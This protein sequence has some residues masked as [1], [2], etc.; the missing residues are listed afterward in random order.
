[1]NFENNGLKSTITVGNTKLSVL[2][3]AL[4]VAGVIVT[5]AVK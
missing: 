5:F 1:M 3:L 4:V 2:G